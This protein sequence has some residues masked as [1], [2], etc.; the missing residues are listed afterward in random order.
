MT[1]PAHRETGAGT[2]MNVVA[3]HPFRFCLAM[4]G[5]Q[6]VLNLLFYGWSRIAIELAAFSIGIGLVFAVGIYGWQRI[7]K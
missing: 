2:R 3:K 5:A 1:D 6:A 7:S 4:A